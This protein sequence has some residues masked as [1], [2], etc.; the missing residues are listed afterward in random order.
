MRRLWSKNWVRRLWGIS[1]CCKS[2][3]GKNETTILFPR[4]TCYYLWQGKRKRSRKKRRWI[5]SA[6]STSSP[7]SFGTTFTAA[8]W[9][10]I[11]LALLRQLDGA[12]KADPSFSPRIVTRN[13][14]RPMT[15]TSR[16][17][18]TE[19]TKKRKREIP[20]EI[21][22]ETKLDYFGKAGQEDFKGKVSTPF[23]IRKSNIPVL[24]S[25]F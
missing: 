5:A 8:H 25:E 1:S 6:Q 21:F 11:R 17:V 14:S 12:Q 10:N 15:H 4:Q 9:P 13:L 20:L 7:M 2:S 16:Y 24:V 18:K 23:L 19:K 22:L 3:W